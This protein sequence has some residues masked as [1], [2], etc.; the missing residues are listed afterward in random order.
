MVTPTADKRSRALCLI[1]EV[2]GGRETEYPREN[3]PTNGIVRHDYNMWK[4][5]VTRPEIEPGSPCVGGE[6]ANHSAI[7]APW[8]VCIDGDDDGIWPSLLHSSENQPVEI[9][10]G[11]QFLSFA[12][13]AVRAHS[14]KI[15]MCLVEGKLPHYALPSS[16][17]WPECLDVDRLRKC[18]DLVVEKQTYP[19]CCPSTKTRIGVEKLGWRVRGRTAPECKGGGKWEIPEKTRRPAA[20]SGKIPTYEDPGVIPPGF[21]PGSSWWEASSLNNYTI[22]APVRER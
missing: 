4:S 18:L 3:L 14:L 7:G 19:R 9:T 8:G 10:S 11:V 2:G 20:S 12:F 5:V 16:T 21:E 22:A 17:E 15:K 1:P 6:Q 13:Y